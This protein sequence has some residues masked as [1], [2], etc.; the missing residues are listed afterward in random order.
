MSIAIPRPRARSGWIM[1]A[2]L[3]VSLLLHAALFF[4]PQIHL[5][6][7]PDKQPSGIEANLVAML[8]V[9]IAVP[10]PMPEP[11]APPA[12]KTKPKPKQPVKTVGP[13]LA[14]P[15]IPKPEIPEPVIPEPV[16]PDAPES[17]DEAAPA[18]PVGD[19][20]T[21]TDEAPVAAAEPTP[22]AE[23][24]ADIMPPPV[25]LA[26][27]AAEPQPPLRLTVNYSLYKGKNG[28]RIGKI[29]HTWD[30]KD[31][32]YVIASVAE[33]AGLARWLTSEMII[34]TSQ[35]RITANGLEPESYWEQR[36]QK[37][38]RTFRAE[39]DYI[40]KTLTY[41]RVEDSTTVPLPP[42]TQ[43]QLSFIYQF[44]LKAPLS[45]T[46]HFSMTTG[47]KLGSY[48]SE[49]VG[50]EM[51]NSGLGELR[52][53]HLRKVRDDPKDDQIEIWLAIDHQYLP[54]KVRIT[55]SDGDVLEQVVEGIRK[56]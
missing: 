44:G 4:V 54:V 11:V 2:A 30:I 56:E 23:S 55:N 21:A 7:F 53:Q 29:V 15:D 38:D 19:E 35:G 26:E 36:G 49:V 47:R 48:A 16:I 43:D 27:V 6:L 32:R 8:K 40:N 46:V 28:L 25:P 31:G 9:Q 45:G 41:G 33:A 52:T 17:L 50:E 37:A 22:V 24:A 51:I 39:F 10:K 13:A 18:E 20:T 1:L 42:G 12:P 3:L 34:Q 5:T 14:V